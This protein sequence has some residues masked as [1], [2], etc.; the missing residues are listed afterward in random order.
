MMH[1]D[2]SIVIANGGRAMRRALVFAMVVGAG[3]GG[4]VMT[5]VAGDP[6]AA[7]LEIP[8]PFARFEHMIGSWKGTAV[9]ATRETPRSSA[10]S[11]T[12]T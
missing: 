7:A 3:F 4:R 9:P 1:A 10:R 6:A 5:A 8:E 2:G 12:S 11:S